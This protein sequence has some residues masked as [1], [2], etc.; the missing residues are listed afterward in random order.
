MEKNDR[1]GDGN[2]DKETDKDLEK[3]NEA[4]RQRYLGRFLISCSGIFASSQRAQFTIIKY[5]SVFSRISSLLQTGKS[6]NQ[7]FSYIP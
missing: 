6:S 3:L 7:F 2:D 5:S 4:I 1:G